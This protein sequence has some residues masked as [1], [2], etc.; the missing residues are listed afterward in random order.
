[1]DFNVSV[2][3]DDQDIRILAPCLKK[4][5]MKHFSALFQII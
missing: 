4:Q 2:G 5:I 1:M 3:D